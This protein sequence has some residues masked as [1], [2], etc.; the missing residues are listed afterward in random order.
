[1]LAITTKRRQLRHQ[2]NKI[3]QLSYKLPM[4]HMGFLI[5]AVRCTNHLVVI[6]LLFWR[7]SHTVHE[8]HQ[9]LYLLVQVLLIA[10]FWRLRDYL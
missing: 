8:V 6:R 3:S 10:M 5:S 4:H 7:Q 9:L 2:L 1:M